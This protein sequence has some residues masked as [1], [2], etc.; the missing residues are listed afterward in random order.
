M[1]ALRPELPPLPWRMQGLPIEE[2]GYPVPKFVQWM[3]A[4]GRPT[5]PGI[6]RP[7][8][9]VAS[10][11]H[12]VRCVRRKVC[13][14]CGMD[15]GNR[16]AFNIGPMCAVNRVSSEPPSHPE[17][18]RYAAMAC[19][20]LVRPHARRREAG[21]P[22]RHEALGGCSIPRN[23]GVALV[24]ITTSYQLFPD[25]M[26]GQ[27]FRVGDPI[28]TEWYREAR[29]A[30]RQEVTDSIESG[31]PQLVAIAKA[32]GEHAVAELETLK[33]EAYRHLPRAS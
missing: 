19:P 20:F 26:G 4:D 25:G 24:W 30:T 1:K 23:P 28:A 27:L 12:F 2:R 3:D 11:E 10:R 16:V 5:P 22:E 29:P 15:L 17:C 9:R 13:W 14:L 8:F 7:D 32:D 18:A 6:G 31:L 21:L 33:A